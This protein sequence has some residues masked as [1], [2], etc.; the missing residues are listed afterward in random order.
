MNRFGLWVDY[1]VVNRFNR[2]RNSSARHNVLKSAYPYIEFFSGLKIAREWGLLM[3][4][5]QYFVPPF[6]FAVS[7][8]P[9]VQLNYSVNYSASATARTPIAPITDA[10]SPVA[11]A[12]IPLDVDVPA[13]LVSFVTVVVELGFVIVLV[14]VSSERPVVAVSAPLE[15]CA[16]TTDM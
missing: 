14:L 3:S 9:T 15:I 7:A 16:R 2:G 10:V 5:I 12:A 1:S 13:G 8:G 6:P 4:Y 11:C